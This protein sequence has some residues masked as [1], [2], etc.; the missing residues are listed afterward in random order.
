MIY[1]EEKQVQLIRYLSI[2]VGV[3]LFVLIFITGGYVP[4]APYW[5]P[6]SRKINTGLALSLLMII[7]APSIVE[8]LNNRYLLP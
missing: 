7:L 2:A 3:L 1:F 6:L 5:V 8:W 4:T